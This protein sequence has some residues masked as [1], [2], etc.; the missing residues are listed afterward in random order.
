MARYFPVE[1]MYE[2]R[3]TSSVIWAIA[4]V[5][6]AAILAS[7]IRAVNHY[8]TATPEYKETVEDIKMCRRMTAVESRQEC[9]DRVVTSYIDS[10]IANDSTHAT[11]LQ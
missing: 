10:S 8:S 3:V 2:S 5:I 7:A 4:F 9:V 1:A 11:L 6:V